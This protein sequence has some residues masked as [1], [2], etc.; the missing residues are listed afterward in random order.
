MK[1]NFCAGKHQNY[2]Q[3]ESMPKVP[4]QVCNVFVIFKKLKKVDFLQTAKHFP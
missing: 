3:V 1:V 2:V 4:R